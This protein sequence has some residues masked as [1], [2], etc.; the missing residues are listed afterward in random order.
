MNPV[1]VLRPDHH[2]QRDTLKVFLAFCVPTFAVLYW[3]TIGRGT[4]L[5]VAICQAAVTVVYG[6]SMIAAYR[7]LIRI[8]QNGI[9]E[10]GFF[11]AFTTF[12]PDQI[13]SLVLLD[14][15]VGGSLDTTRQLFVTG[16]D[17]R[18]LIRLRGQ[19]WS[20]ADMDTVV[21]ELGVPVLH[22][23]QP[24]DLTALN[25]LRPELLY[26]FERR[27]TLRNP[28][29]SCAPLVTSAET[30]AAGIEIYPR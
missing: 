3:I 20:S 8:D 4:W 9:S 18:L 7:A 22:I 28:R 29:R 19:F 17:G 23:P 13:G 26:W 2:V 14:L 16:H 11:R 10:R 27:I 24:L 25:A 30:P 6:L 5:P 21:D 1:I 15:Y 12:P